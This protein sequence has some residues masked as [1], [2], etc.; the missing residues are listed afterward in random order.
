VEDEAKI[1]RRIFDLYTE[2]ERGSYEIAILLNRD[3]LKTTRGK[4]WTGSSVNR[5]LNNEKYKGTVILNR[6]SHTDLT[7]SHRRVI[8]PKNEWIIYEDAI[9]KIV[10]KEQ[11]D[12]AQNIMRSRSRTTRKTEGSD[13]R[14]VRGRK[15]IK[16][17]FHGKMYCHL[18]GADYVRSTTTKIRAG[19]RVKE[20]FYMCRNRTPKRAIEEKCLN[21]GIS[22][23]VL[24]RELTILANNINMSDSRL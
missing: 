17:V 12:K 10:S 24:V 11:F 23:D 18:C 9:P 1:V 8:N 16:N 2:E 22:H 21:K 15:K 3:G 13:K 19:K 7:G 20:Y 5:V 6:Y 14:Q 4:D